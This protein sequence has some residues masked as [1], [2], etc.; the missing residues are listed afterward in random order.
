MVTADQQPHILIIDDTPEILDLL[1]ELL[2]DE[3]YRVSTSREPLDLPGI[4]ALA[5]DLIVQDVLFP[6]SREKGWNLLTLIQ[7]DPELARIP[8]VL[9]TAASGL[10]N[11]P[12]MAANLNRLGVRVIL[13]PFNLD[14]LLDALRESLAA[15]RLLRDS[16][17]IA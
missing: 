2:E 16:M 14:D 10:V 9:C 7:I 12:T 8:L 11:E 6:N 17:R 3:G 13:K 5:P 1:R 4:K 15:R